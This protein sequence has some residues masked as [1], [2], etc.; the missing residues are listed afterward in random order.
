MNDCVECGVE[1]ESDITIS[2][3]NE[4]GEFEEHEIPACPD[5]ILSF[6]VEGL[7]GLDD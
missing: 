7:G 1:T 4:D 5:C 3:E 6:V 2:G